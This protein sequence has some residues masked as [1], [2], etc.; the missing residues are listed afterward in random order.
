MAA[1]R[2]IP[3]DIEVTGGGAKGFVRNLV[4]N[5]IQLILL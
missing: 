5:S 2:L 1:A 3:Y 4:F